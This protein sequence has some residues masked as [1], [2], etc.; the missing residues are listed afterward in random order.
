MLLTQGL[1]PQPF[2]GKVAVLV[3]E[4]TNSAA[5]MLAGFASE[6]R[7][8]TVVGTKT[9]GNVLGAVNQ[10]LGGGYWLRVPVFG[11]YTSEGKCLEGEGVTPDRKVEVPK[12][13]DAATD[14]EMRFA[15]E[16]LS[17]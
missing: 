8:A 11:W 1:G 5:E 16:V 7:L 6:N 14:H 3:N 13:V 12:D 4:W 9:A 17:N 2:H 15:S 10:K